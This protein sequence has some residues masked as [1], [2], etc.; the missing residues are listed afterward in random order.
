MAGASPFVARRFGEVALEPCYRS[1]MGAIP[2]GALH[3]VRRAADMPYEET[4]D[5]N[6]YVSLEA[7][8]GHRLGPGRIGD[9]ELEEHEGPASCGSIRAGPVADLRGDE[10]EGTDGRVLAPYEFG[11]IEAPW[12]RT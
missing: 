6:L 10:V 9:I 12:P 4:L 3:A 8:R 5:R 7:M 2:A 1:V 11:V